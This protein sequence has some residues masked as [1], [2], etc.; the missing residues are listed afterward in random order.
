METSLHYSLDSKQLSFKLREIITANLGVELKAHGLFNTVTSTFD[1]NAT[2]KKKVSTGPAVKGLGNEPLVIAGGLKLNSVSKN[3]VFLT[4]SAKKKLSLFDGPNTT[5]S[6]K[7]EIDF[8]PKQS[9]V[10]LLVNC[11]IWRSLLNL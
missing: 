10:R 1:Y 11:C 4:A 9:K 2:L 3:D 7:A 8:D 6:V 5:L